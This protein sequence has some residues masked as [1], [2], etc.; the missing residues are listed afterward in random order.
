MK[1]LASLRAVFWAATHRLQLS[2]EIDHELQSHI[3]LRADDLERRGMDRTQAERQARV[4][5]GACARYKE[6][7]HQAAGGALGQTLWRDIR[8]AFKL[9]RKFP[10]LTAVAIGTLALG[11]GANTAIFSLVDAIWLRPL[12]IADP[13]HL[14][15]IASVKS[16][17]SANSELASTGSSYSEFEDLRAHVPA[18]SDVAAS[19]RRS[20]V[21]QTADGNQLLLANVVSDNYFSFIGVRL[22]LGRLPLEDELKNYREPV[23]F[24]SH[25]TWKRVFGSNPNIVGQTLKIKGSPAVVLGVMPAG[26]RGTE[27]FIDPQV[28]VP[29]SAWYI[30]DPSENSSSASSRNNREYEIYARLRQGAT[31]DQARA[32]LQSLSAVLA[33][34]F[35]QANS[36]RSFTADWQTKSH[37]DQMKVLSLL[38]LAIAGAVLLIAC[39]NIANLLLALNDSRRREFAMRVA[40]GASRRQLLR[41]LLTEYIMLA[42]A[43]VAGALI[44]AQ[45]LVELVP[46]L[47]PDIGFPIGFDL[48]LDHRVLAVTAVTGFM[49]VLIAGLLPGLASTRT[50]PLEAMRAQTWLGNRLKITARKFF[51]VAQLS[52]SMTLLVATGLLV[53]TLLHIENMDMGFNSRQNAALL[54]VAVDGNGPRMQAEFDALVHRLKALPGVKDACMARVVPFPDSGGGATRVVLAPDEVPS[55]TAGTSVWFNWVG[56]GYFRVMGIP[57]IRGRTFDKPDTTGKLPVAIVNQALAI[58]L[59]GSDDVVGRHFRIGRE[60]P[61]NVEVIGVAQNGKYAD[62]AEVQQPYLYLPVTPDTWSNAT[63]IA[64]T[65]GDPHAL[66][67]AAREAVLQTSPKTLILSMQ[68]MTDHMLMAN[69]PNHLAAWLCASLGGLALLLTMIGLYGVTAYSVSRRTHEIGVRM[70]LGALRGT[71]FAAVLKDGL[72]LTLIGIALGGGLALLVCRAMSSL[73]FGVKPFDPATLAGAVAVVLATSLAALIGPARRAL[74]VDPVNAL[75]DE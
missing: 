39:T 55:P 74:S 48:R 44:L 19:D 17:A 65:A 2:R 30:W 72:K 51:V 47:I 45:R 13:S 70:A 33:S 35:P 5:L 22:E 75:R 50:S 34:E 42:I 56:D 57:I 62:V 7:S 12:P 49:S 36:G 3:L 4:E 63:L 8:F 26:F 10:L 9:F 71:V 28:Y 14:V 58:K 15:A 73:L 21:L 60:Q 41:Q 66:L 67:P 52:A 54:E 29:L 61:Q 20:V 6:A 64:T 59:F 16:H 38:L 24:L 23:V 53:R 18:F 25:S 32:Q 69:F 27:R 46:A 37:S 68:T 1:A 43:G 31:L 40:L 11:I